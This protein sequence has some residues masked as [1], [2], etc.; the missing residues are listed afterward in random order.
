MG[1]ILHFLRDVVSAMRGPH[2][3]LLAD[4]VTLDLF[5]PKERLFVIDSPLYAK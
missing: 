2:S 5:N 1:E 4:G 3:W